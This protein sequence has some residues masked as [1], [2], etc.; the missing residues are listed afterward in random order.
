MEHNLRKRAETFINAN[1]VETPALS[2]AEV[3]T[4]FRELDLKQVQLAM[5][6][7]ELQGAVD[8]LQAACDAYADLYDA[9]PVGY[10]TMDRCNTIQ[11]ANAAAARM[12]G[13]DRSQLEGRRFAEFVQRG[14][15]C[16]WERHCD[17]VLSGNHDHAVDVELHRS[18]GTSFFAQL[19]C[20]PRP[21]ETPDS[22]QCLGILVDI[23]ARKRA[24]KELHEREME[25]EELNQELEGRI[26]ARSAELYAS[27]SRFR[28]LFK[29]SPDAFFLLNQEGCFIDGNHA[30]ERQI[31]YTCDE[32]VGQ[33]VFESPI[34]SLAARE[35][36]R[37]RI[38]QLAAGEQLA[39]TEYELVC[40]DGSCITVEVTT[41]MVRIGSEPMLLCS[42]RDLSARKQAAAERELLA[43]KL[44]LALDTAQ[45]G[46]WFYDPQTHHST[47]DRRY[48][49]IF[50]VT[51]AAKPIEK[52]MDLLH[53]DDRSRVWQQVQAALNPADPQS[54]A[55]Q[56]RIVRPDGEMRWIEARGMAVF[57]NEGDDRRARALIGTVADITERTA[58]EEELRL[59]ASELAMS[60]QR[61]RQR[62]ASEL[63]DGL[64]Q[65][66]NSANV[67]LDGIADEDLPERASHS[68]GKARRI[69]QETIGLTRSLTFDLSCP[70]LQELGLAAAL[71]E[72]CKS[73][74]HEHAIRFKFSCDR[75]TQPMPLDQQMILYRGVR[76]LLVNVLKHSEATN[77]EVRME[78]VDKHVRI[79]VSDDGKGFD[80]KTAG[81]GFSPSGGFGLFN[82]GEHMQH[83][84][85][86]LKI[87]SAP[88]SGTKVEIIIPLEEVEHG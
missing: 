63:H 52:I 4:L 30:V 56:Y 81:R 35:H 83:L 53:P 69:L 29:E 8:E 12:F 62:I 66:L 55:S 10:L 71:E 18:D 72:L 3:Q 11:R 15:H 58:R 42:S 45:L 85:G 70:V 23:T 65:L 59:L 13:I 14:H 40:K 64:S 48:A 49:E 38:Q 79:F 5:Q 87:E 61:E 22:W 50:G 43:K 74:S 37:Q 41:R 33:S 44:Q 6:N 76:E 7:K 54:Y 75:Q 9:A 88:E 16:L 68:L 86:D 27:E 21:G 31:G 46:W 60:E 25:L 20:R 84:G 82:L 80:A 51:D 19:I 2:T 1:P 26:A 77:A 34:F 39:P 47:Y 73:M 32:L 78:C 17:E 36:A 57:K 28:A 24:E 67:W